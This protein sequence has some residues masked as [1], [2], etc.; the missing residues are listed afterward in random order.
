[1]TLQNRIHVA[2]MALCLVFASSGMALA[3]SAN[4][5]ANA[6]LQAQSDTRIQGGLTDDV[7][8]RTNGAA[9]FGL[10]TSAPARSEQAGMS[11]GQTHR[12]V[13][14]GDGSAVLTG[15]GTAVMGRSDTAAGLD[16]SNT[17]K[18]TGMIGIGNTA[19]SVGGIG[20]SEHAEG[21][22]GASNA[23]AS[24]EAGVSVGIGVGGNG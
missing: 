15:N 14:S 11:Q 22:G 23:G 8:T 4:A 24:A 2:P 10:D 7:E 21:H 5:D 18:A 3:Q 20:V 16:A 6:D 13:V 1:M 9:R 19:A 12:G 17:T